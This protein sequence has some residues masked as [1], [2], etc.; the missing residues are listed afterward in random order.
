MPGDSWDD[1]TDECPLPV[2]AHMGVV[3]G[4]C[5]LRI[6]E[7]PTEENLARLP[8]I[9]QMYQEM[10]GKLEREVGTRSDA[11]ARGFGLAA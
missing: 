11:T 1:D 9:E 7:L 10:R 4:A 8:L 6:T 2:V 3:F 5:R